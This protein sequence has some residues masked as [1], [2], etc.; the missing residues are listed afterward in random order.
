MKQGPVLKTLKIIGISLLLFILLTWTYRAVSTKQLDDVSSDIQCDREL[1]LKADVL[2]VIPRFENNSIAKNPEW[3][4]EILELN[5]TLALHGVSHEYNEFGTDK[6]QEYLDAGM[7]E[8]YQCFGFY[9]T[10]FKAPQLNISENNKKLISQNMT[11][12]GYPNQGLH[13][14][15]H[16]NDTGILSNKFTE[17][18]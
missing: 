8:F 5:K 16:C 17:F 2:F 18:F 12:Y 15:Y 7:E 4:R 11:F 10:I 9:P 14:A 1:M 6:T 3:C 13:K